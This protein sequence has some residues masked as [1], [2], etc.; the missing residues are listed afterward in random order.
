MFSSAFEQEERSFANQKRIKSLL[1]TVSFAALL[2]L[3]FYLV[4]L[5]IPNPPF[6]ELSAGGVEINFGFDETGTGDEQAFSD[7]PGPISETPASGATSA[8]SSENEET[9]TQEDE[10]TEVIVEKPTDKPKV[11][12]TSTTTTTAKTTNTATVNTNNKTNTT[13]EPVQKADPDAL[14]PTKGAK[15]TPNKSTGDGTGGGKGDQGS[16][17]GDPNSKSYLGGGDGSGRYTAKE[18]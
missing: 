1:A 9:L 14:F 3:A 13:S 17:E 7:N 4:K 6:P 5:T 16:P 8:A 2:L 10:E 18:I 12:P 15:G 11:K